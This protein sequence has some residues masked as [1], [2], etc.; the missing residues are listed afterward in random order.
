[1]G[2]CGRSDGTY[3]LAGAE[4]EAYALSPRSIE[5]GQMNALL[6]MTERNRGWYE[7]GENGVAGGIVSKAAG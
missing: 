4:D 3:G 2:A 5:E 7:P 1:M 6:R